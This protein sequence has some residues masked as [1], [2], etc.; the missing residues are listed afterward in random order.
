VHVGGEPGKG[1]Q[2]AKV[3]TVKQGQGAN[4]RNRKAASAFECNIRDVFLLKIDSMSLVGSSLLGEVTLR[5]LA[6]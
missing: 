4:I 5:L 1:R 6:A 2:A 3:L